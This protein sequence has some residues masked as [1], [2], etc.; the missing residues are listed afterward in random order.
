M[1]RSIKTFTTVACSTSAAQAL[2]ANGN[3]AGFTLQNNSDVDIYVLIRKTSSADS[4]EVTT[5]NGIKLA[6][7]ENW[8]LD[9]SECPDGEIRAIAASGSSKT[10]VVVEW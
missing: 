1:A 4:T 5:S 10:L 7:G 8:F 2:A 6:S 3:R 9:G